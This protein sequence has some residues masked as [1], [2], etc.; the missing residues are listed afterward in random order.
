MLAKGL[1][2]AGAPVSDQL[3]QSAVLSDQGKYE[4]AEEMHRVLG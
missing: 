2:W 4:Q 3:I 1:L